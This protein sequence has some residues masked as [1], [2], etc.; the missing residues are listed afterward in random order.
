GQNS[1]V[2]D[3][4]EASAEQQALDAVDFATL[5]LKLVPADAAEAA[6]HAV[7]LAEIDKS[8]GGKTLWRALEPVA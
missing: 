8:S 1:L 5:G 2:I 3:D 4:A 6:A 7:V